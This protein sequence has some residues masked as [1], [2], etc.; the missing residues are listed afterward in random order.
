MGSS[1][2]CDCG[3]CRSAA[4]HRAD[5]TVHNAPTLPVDPC[6]CGAVD[7]ERFAADLVRRSQQR[8]DAAMP[9]LTL[10]IG[11]RGVIEG[12]G[13]LTPEGRSVRPLPDASPEFE[14]L[15]PVRPVR[16]RGRV[17]S[18]L[19]ASLRLVARALVARR[20]R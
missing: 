19:S 6:D 1:K 2:G 15:L 11:E 10:R 20:S 5:C 4:Q 12:L 17:R 16:R 14:R 7:L 8:T 13:L 18:L 3:K 9:Q